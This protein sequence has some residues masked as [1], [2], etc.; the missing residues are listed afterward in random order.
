MKTATVSIKSNSP[1]SPSRWFQMEA[2]RDQKETGLDYEQRT[3]NLR[4][5]VDETGRGFIPPMAFKNCLADA[6]RYL[7][8][9]IPG[10]RNATYSKHFMAGVIVTEGLPLAVT[11]E[12]VAGE[13]LFLHADG[14]KGGG[15]RVPKRYPCVIEWSGKVDFVVL[16]DTITP[17]VFEE[18]LTE[19]GRF[20]GIGRF[21]PQNGGYYGRFS[22]DGISWN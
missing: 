17:E 1:Y 5:H 18:H 12:T 21:R 19:A 7:S 2:P 4:L 10:K 16:D 3:W 13:W 15:T 22:V 20:I 14:K 11:R 6:A 9:K 8:K